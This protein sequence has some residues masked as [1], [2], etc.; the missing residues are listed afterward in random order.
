MVAHGHPPSP[1]II[2]SAEQFEILPVRPKSLTN[3]IDLLRLLGVPGPGRLDN[4]LDSLKRLAAVE[5]TFQEYEA[6]FGGMPAYKSAV[7]LKSSKRRFFDPRDSFY[8]PTR[9]E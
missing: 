9:K 2:L 4:I 6:S 7:C 8:V 1:Q 3:V 5:I